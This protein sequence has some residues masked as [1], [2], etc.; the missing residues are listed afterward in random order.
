MKIF[1]F[2]S[3]FLQTL[4][5]SY[6]KLKTLDKDLKIEQ[7]FYSLFKLD[8]LE[9][10]MS[11]AV[12]V[13]LHANSKHSRIGPASH[14]GWQQLVRLNRFSWFKC[15]AVALAQPNPNWNEA[16]P[17]YTKQNW[18]PNRSL[19]VIQPK[20]PPALSWVSRSDDWIVPSHSTISHN[21]WASSQ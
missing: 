16:F 6:F 7:P 2:T 21:S 17:L 15:Q 8:Y 5:K 1:L 14:K 20:Y 4:Y 11:Y 13:P 19:W 10:L 18:V 12:A 9:M 3:S